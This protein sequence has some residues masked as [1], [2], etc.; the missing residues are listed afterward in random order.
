MATVAQR[1]RQESIER[2]RQMSPTERLF[3]ALAL[4]RA[5]VLAYARAHE[6]DVD[7]ARRRLERAGQ[8]GRRA[9]RVMEGILE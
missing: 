1:L 6:L 9:S 4:G 8:A 3:E 2:A 7:E 5:A